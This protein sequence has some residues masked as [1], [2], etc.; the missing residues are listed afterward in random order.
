MNK[1]SLSPEMTFFIF[2]LQQYAAH[3]HITADQVLHDMDEKGLT[4]FIYSMY[5]RYHTEAIE[6]AFA[7]LDSL[8]ATGKPQQP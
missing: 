3:R 2:L 8:L 7:D 4:N 5:D 6:N 1:L